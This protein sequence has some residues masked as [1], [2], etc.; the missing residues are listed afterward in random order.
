MS[1]R[2]SVRGRPVRW[3]GTSNPR[4][5]RNLLQ[6]GEFAAVR[7]LLNLEHPTVVCLVAPG[8]RRP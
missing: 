1:I 2:H 6:D 5:E 4:L 8:T 7:G 3:L